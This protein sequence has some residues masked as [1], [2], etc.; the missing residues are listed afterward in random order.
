MTPKHFAYSSL[1]IFLQ[2]T[3]FHHVI[4]QVTFYVLLTDNPHIIKFTFFGW[5]WWFMPVIPALRE[6]KA[7]GS[8]EVRSSRPAWA[9]W[10]S[11]VF[12]KHTNYLGVVVCDCSSKLFGRLR[13]KGWLSLG[14][15]GCSDLRLWHCT[16][17]LQPGNR[18]RLCLKKKNDMVKSRT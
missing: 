7:S 1:V 4:L 13:W 17:V 10:Q 8:P 12:T 18:V 15:R 2:S 5:A 16:T 3:V 6:A 11:P 14:D 9:T